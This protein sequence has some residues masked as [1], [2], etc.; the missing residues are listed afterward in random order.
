M[1][2]SGSIHDEIARARKAGYEQGVKDGFE[3]G[4][5]TGEAAVYQSLVNLRKQVAHLQAEVQRLT[6]TMAELR[7]EIARLEQVPKAREVVLPPELRLPGPEALTI[8]HLRGE[9]GNNPLMVPE[10]NTSEAPPSLDPEGFGGSD[11]E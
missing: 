1:T 6:P 9:P 5:R 11:Y 10:V 8:A 2:F 7:A 4:K 3:R